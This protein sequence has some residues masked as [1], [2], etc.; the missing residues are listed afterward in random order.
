MKT[1]LP[2]LRRANL[3]AWL[4]THATP[5]KERSYFSQL[6]VG[7]APFGERAARRLEHDYGMGDHYL[8]TPQVPKN[9]KPEAA[10]VVDSMDLVWVTPREMRLLTSFRASTE[11]GKV[12]V[13]VSA[14]TSEKEKSLLRIAGNDQPK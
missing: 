2:Y 5:A 10:P 6:V 8:D 7:T 3:K 9:E 12:E 14:R 4:E 11:R 13:E 1:D